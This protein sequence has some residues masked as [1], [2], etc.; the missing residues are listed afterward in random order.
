M[1]IEC[2][3]STRH[4]A[5]CFAKPEKKKVLWDRYNLAASLFCFFGFFFLPPKS[6]EQ[7]FCARHWRRRQG[8]SKD[9]S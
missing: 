9:E 3:L 2:I 6:F 4:H 1:F 5:A 8:H 7:V